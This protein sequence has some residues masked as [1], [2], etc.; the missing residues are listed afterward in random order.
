MGRDKASLPFRG[1]PMVEIAVEKL[2]G[3]CADVA[4][5]ANREDLETYA[6]IVRESRLEAGPVAGIEAS[7]Q[8]CSQA[9]AL[10]IPVDVPVVSPSF[11]RLWAEAV[12]VQ[13][14]RGCG[15]SSLVVTHREQPAFCMLRRS[16][17]PV[18]TKA[19][20]AGERRLRYLLATL[21][22]EGDGGWMWACDAGQLA[23]GLLD[24]KYSNLQL[25][26]WFRN[27]NTPDEL[28][29]AESGFGPE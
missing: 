1:R 16:S 28:Q 21:E 5:S 27:V 7:L 11:L 10:F 4:I 25:E 3:F 15:V 14:G 26:N 24:P 6:P 22:G 20:D 12:L 8:A 2:R 18:I 23:E 19:I 9:W 17:L 29:E 13:A